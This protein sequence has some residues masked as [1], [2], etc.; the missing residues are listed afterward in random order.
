MTDA[1]ASKW[2]KRRFRVDRLLQLRRGHFNARHARGGHS[3]LHDRLFERH[4]HLPEALAQHGGVHPCLGLC[5]WGL[6]IVYCPDECL[7][8]DRMAEVQ[9]VGELLPHF[10]R[11]HG[12]INQAFLGEKAQQ[13]R[14]V[15][16]GTRLDSRHGQGG[17]KK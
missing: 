1:K 17:L 7:Q 5:G 11:C 2:V 3:A 6:W 9:P 14:A 16:T 12:S 8:G 13:C 15:E 10:T 4:T